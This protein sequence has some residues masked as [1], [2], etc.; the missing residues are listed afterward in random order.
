MFVTSSHFVSSSVGR[1][2]CL[3]ELLARQEVFLFFTGLLQNFEILPPEGRDAIAFTPV[4]SITVAPSPY[5]VRFVP[6]QK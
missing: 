3:G 5:D 1:R 2:A 6:R 4:T